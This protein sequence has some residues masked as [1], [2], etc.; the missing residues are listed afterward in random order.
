MIDRK[1]KLR[2]YIMLLP[3]LVFIVG[4][5]ITGIVFGL[6]QSFGYYPAIG[7]KTFTIDYYINI[8]SDDNFLSSLKFSV[9]TSLVS[10]FLSVIFGLILAYTLVSSSKNTKNRFINVYKLPIMVPHT[11]AALLTFMLFTQ[12][13]LMSRIFYSLGIISE[14]SEFPHLIFDKNGFGIILAYLW[15]GMPFITLITYDVLQELNE[16]Y[17]KVAANLGSNKYQIFWHVLL[18]L[19]IPTIASGFIIIFAFSFGAYEIQYLLGASTP[20]ALPILSYIYYNSVNLED[21]CNAMVINVCISI[22]SFILV[23]VFMLA[24]RFMMKNK[25]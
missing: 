8:F 13:G 3:L 6:F 7:L 18:P 19:I 4:I 25:N 2:P 20:K 16:K 22:C 10:S 1:T 11:I 17:S 12:S 24:N 5:F 14:M 23:G 21:R 15:K 9:Y